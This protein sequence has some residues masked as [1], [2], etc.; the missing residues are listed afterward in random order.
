MYQRAPKQHNGEGVCAHV[1][2]APE[3]LEEISGEKCDDGVLGGDDLVG[4]V[5][6][7]LL[8]PALCVEI[9]RGQVL[10]DIDAAGRS[11]LLFAGEK[12][13]D[14]ECCELFVPEGELALAGL[15]AFGAGRH[16]CREKEQ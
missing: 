16:D 3:L 6:V 2:Y 11:W 10:V 8:D 13:A 1:G 14:L 4:R 5:Y 12:G 9:V 15:A 7:L